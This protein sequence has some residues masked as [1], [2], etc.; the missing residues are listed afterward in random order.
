MSFMKMDGCF[1]MVKVETVTIA[2]SSDMMD[3]IRKMALKDYRSINKQIGYLLSQA[4]K[5][6][7]TGQ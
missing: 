5:A 3:I 6:E 1:N 2:L 7:S 4:I